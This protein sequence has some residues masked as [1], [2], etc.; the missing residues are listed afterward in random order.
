MPDRR[1]S[2]VDL[3]TVD[4]VV[5][6]RLV[7]AATTDAL[8]DEVTPRLTSDDDGWSTARVTWLRHFHR[9]RRLGL[10][11]LPGEATW[12]L[13][14][15]D[16][17]VGSVRLKRTDD[18]GVLETGVW[19]RRSARGQGI[20]RDAIA[21]VVREAAALGAK[22]LVAETRE[23]N[24]AALSV[25]AGGGFATCPPDSS[26]QVRAVLRFPDRTPLPP[27]ERSLD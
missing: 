16:H 6:E 13:V 11:G 7:D 22:A 10:D 12:A 24:R 27:P 20:G 25:L 17:V 5:L 19:L 21:A 23:S 1:S 4:E 26:G 3:V 8:A 9:D 2:L 14:A 15:D 18:P